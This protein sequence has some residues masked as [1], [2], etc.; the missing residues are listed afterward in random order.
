MRKI[1]LLL[2]TLVAVSCT[3]S[4]I[5][6]EEGGG[7]TGSS[8]SSSSTSVTDDATANTKMDS[9]LKSYY[10]YNEEYKTLSPN[11]D[12]LYSD[13]VDNTLMSMSTNVLDYKNGSL[14]SYVER[15]A[16]SKADS[17][18]SVSK[19]LTMS[20]GLA[21]LVLISFA[22]SDNIYIGIQAV[23]PDSPADDAGLV[24]G[25]VISEVNGVA[26]TTSNCYGYAQLLLSPTS[27]AT[28]SLKILNGRASFTQDVT[29]R[30]IYPN[31]VLKCEMLTPTIGYLN[32]LSFDSAYDTELEA[33]LTSLQSAGATDLILD[34]R[35]N[36]GGYVTSARKLASSIAGANGVGQIFQK[37][38]YNDDI[39]ALDSSLYTTQENFIQSVPQLSLTKLYCLVSGLTASASEIIINSLRGI[40][41]PVTLIGSQTEGKNVGM[42]ELT[43]STDDW[44]YTFLPI[45]FQ[46]FN[47]KDASDYADGFMVNYS[48]DDWNN[49]DSFADFTSSEV[50]IAK[51]L[52]LISGSRSEVDTT[53]STND[54]FSSTPAKSIQRLGS[55]SSKSGS[56]ILNPTN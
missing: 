17:R 22:D 55:P 35:L 23:Y 1:I 30:Q 11:F 53:S 44:D 15:T 28:L 20:Y 32:Y 48:V 16:K 14:Y 18:S 36:G 40:D 9:Y 6:F 2:T 8:S 7:S 3:E 12:L 19:E 31:P 38:R 29:S 49:G 41:F 24:R 26:V 56:I 39:T 27:S 52:S 13:F 50:M 54:L 43:F 21:S 33:A 34:L 10:L 46:N 25:Y 42:F 37:Y 47:A 5:E 45:S 4:N 51:A